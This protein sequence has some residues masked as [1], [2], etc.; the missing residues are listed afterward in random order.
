M[1]QPEQLLKS[2]ETFL[3]SIPIEKYRKELM[4]I[5][6]VEQD[7]PKT[8]NPLPNL[9]QTYWT[10]ES[11]TFIDYEQFFENWW[12]SHLNQID[13]FIRQYFWGCSLEFV[14]LGFKARLYRIFIS[15]LTQF[16]F[17][18]LWKAYCDYPIEAS[19][20]LD[21]KGIDA[22]VHINNFRVALQIKKETYRSE[23]RERGRFATRKQD[24]DLNVEVPYTVMPPEEWQKKISKAKKEETKEQYKLFSCLTKNYQD[25]LENGF[26]IFKQS[27]SKVVEGF[28]SERIKETGII[29]WQEVLNYLKSENCL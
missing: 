25:W 26:V 8:L 22:L 19:A 14:Y 17:V 6:T 15:V 24:V 1:S 28:I 7:L 11:K 16:H 2:F 5:K 23:A 18:Y 13:E 10:N 20:D 27:Y 4:P 21:I 9:Y 3:A 29:G 12:K